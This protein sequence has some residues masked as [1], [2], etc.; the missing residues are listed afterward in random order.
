MKSKDLGNLG[1]NMATSMLELSG[2]LIIERNWRAKTGEELDII[3]TRKGKW[4]ITEVKTRSSLDFGY[5]S[6]AIN[7]RKIYSMNKAFYKFM[8]SRKLDYVEPHI[9]ILEILIN[10]LHY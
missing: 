3:S 10:N 2:H 7:K 1:E 8:K 6:E 5:P 4:Y 9:E